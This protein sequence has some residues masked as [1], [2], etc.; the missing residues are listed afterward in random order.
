MEIARPNYTIWRMLGHS[1][2]NDSHFKQRMEWKPAVE[3]GES[4][5]EGISS[6]AA[7]V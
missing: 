6:F 3:N 1:W 7:E 2:R 4:R 5:P